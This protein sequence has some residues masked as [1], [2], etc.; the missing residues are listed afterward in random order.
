MTGTRHWVV[1][2]SGQG[3]Y[4]LLEN[5]GETFRVGPWGTIEKAAAYIDAHGKDN[6]EEI[7][8]FQYQNFDIAQGNG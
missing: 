4:A 3:Y 1:Q 5:I 7:K 6:L 2:A 8:L